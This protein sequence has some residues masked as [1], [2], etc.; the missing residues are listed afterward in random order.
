MDAGGNAAHWG[1]MAAR[2][3][4]GIHPLRHNSRGEALCVCVRSFLQNNASLIHYILQVPVTSAEEAVEVV[5]RGSRAR[6][7]ARTALN[8]ASSRSHSI[9]SIMVTRPQVG[10]DRSQQ[11]HDCLTWRAT[12]GPEPTLKAQNLHLR[13]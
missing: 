12:D 11:M 10:Y 8:Q 13:L 6:Q 1:E 7:K 5:R 2:P 4:Q 9:S 3:R